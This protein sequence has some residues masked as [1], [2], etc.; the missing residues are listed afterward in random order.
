MRCMCES[1][2]SG[3]VWR[4]IDKEG[5]RRLREDLKGIYTR[6]G[7]NI[8]SFSGRRRQIF[9]LPPWGIEQRE[10]TRENGRD[11]MPRG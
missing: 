5:G 8:E 9:R 1:S 6:P 4:E 7:K 3:E 2:C 11:Y 10:K